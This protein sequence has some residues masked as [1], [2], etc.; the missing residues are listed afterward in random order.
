MNKKV[1]TLCAGFLL[2]GGLFSTANA[3]DLRN[4]IPGQYY[5]LK[6]TA[7]YQNSD[8]EVATTANQ[9]DTWFAANSAGKAVLTQN[10][11]DDNSYWTIEVKN[12]D[13]G[14]KIVR[15]VNVHTGK[16]LSVKASDG[17]STEWF[18]VGYTAAGNFAG[19]TTTE[20][21]N[22][23]KWGNGNVNYLAI[24][25]DG[26]EWVYTSGTVAEA[27]AATPVV[28][29]QGIDAVAVEP[30]V[31]TGAELNSVYED[32][33]ALQICYQPL[34]N[35]NTELDTDKAPVEYADL[36]GNPFTGMLVA[37]PNDNITTSVALYQG[38][39][40]GKRIVLTSDTWGSQAGGT[41]QTGYKF[42]AYTASEYRANASKI[43]ANEFTIVQPAAKGGAPLEVSVML[44]TNN[45]ETADTK[46]ELVVTNAI[47]DEW[48][49]TV[50]PS[51]TATTNVADYTFT[52]GAWT[53]AHQNTYVQFGITNMVDYSD[54]YG[55]LWNIYKDG[56]VATPSCAVTEAYANDSNADSWIPVAQ[57]AANYP[58][59]QW[60][61]DATQDLD[62][63]GVAEG[64]FVNRESGHVLSIPNLR[65]VEGKD[66]TYTKGGAT[67]TISP[68]GD[69]SDNYNDG[70]LAGYTTDQLKQK[71]FFIGTPIAATKD[72]V[73][74]SKAANGKL[75]FVED[76]AE[77]AEFRLTMADFDR[78]VFDADS[79]LTAKNFTSY[80]VW[81]DKNA[82]TTEQK[83]DVVNFHKYF[84]TEAVSGDRLNYD[85]E[86]ERFALTDE[87]SIFN[88]IVIKKKGNEVYNLLYNV[89]TDF[90]DTNNDG[91]NDTYATNQNTTNSFCAAEKLYGA[92]NVAELVKS[93]GAYGFTE[94]D[95]FVVV[96]AD[97]QQYRGD[98][99]NTG[100][101]DTIKIF[102]NDDNSYVLYEKGELLK[103]GN[104]VVEGFL[105]M[106]NINDPQ[107]ADMHA[108]MLADTAF[109]SNTYRP[110]YMLA[111]DADIVDDGWTCPLN[112]LY[113]TPEWREENGG[114]CADA[115]KDRPY[116]TGRY[117]VNLVDSAEAA[118][119]EGVKFADNKFVHEYY[120]TPA[121]PYYRL[122]FVQAK[123][124]GD[125]LIIASTNDTI[126][127]KNN[128]EDQ[129]CTF[130]FRYVDAERDAFTIE[131][132]YRAYDI[133]EDG[134]IE[135][136]QR[137]YIKYQNGIPVVTPKASEAWVFD[138]NETSE[139]PT[140]NET[141]EDAANSAVTVVA[142][143]GAVI[144]RG[145]EGKNVIVSTILGKVVANEVIN[146]DNE[147]IAA[148]AGI[149][150]VSVDGESFKVA[151]K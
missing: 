136:R 84:V 71:A 132:L 125:S 146:S 69:P 11:T 62:N 120:N 135:Y 124:I 109:Y 72:T 59:G 75:E 86:N 46:Y 31:L 14:V 89:E 12:N 150:V 115:V 38:S 19:K 74:L 54:F 23:L 83:T 129:V 65:Y 99:S 94:N 64:A 143:D 102:R 2:A 122:G 145:A 5:Q 8:W 90:I 106:E 37:V 70:Y 7:Q 113:D 25:Q 105:G 148:P 77:A 96:D 82:G 57:V 16:A 111:V 49:L 141:I 92:Q 128:P 24:T 126:N 34:K 43:I 17:T 36:Q 100:V 121:T 119:A 108:A 93:D 80:T 138:L 147:T 32:G 140:A 58:E 27:N 142:T 42:A 48:C 130:A 44:D 104:E 40:K 78:N 137:G 18:E 20:D 67:Y 110:Q 4:A 55:K 107:Y 45:D 79:Y 13:N 26:S 81:K 60:L 35:N 6:R 134:D 139:T 87:F 33:F 127:L 39:T 112:P 22:E 97:A 151:V 73:W 66:Y 116:I 95:M 28:W 63:D 30:D 53:S 144:V 1:L 123:H 51:N 61:F 29:L 101:L 131:T 91:E 85:S 103:K 41:T 76:K 10:A 68:A 117:L 21:V 149:V 98:F 114:P 88:P 9:L 56:K 50:A 3:I 118:T 52:N 133:D 47:G 15:L